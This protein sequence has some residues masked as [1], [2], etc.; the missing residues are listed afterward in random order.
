MKN[1]LDM[2]NPSHAFKNNPKKPSLI[3]LEFEGVSPMHGG[4]IVTMD[5]KP[6][7]LDPNNSVFR[8]HTEQ[9]M[10]VNGHITVDG[11]RYPLVEG[12][13]YRDKSWGPRHWH[14]FFWYRWVPMTFSRDFG[15]LLSINGRPDDVPH[16]SGNVLRNGIYEPVRK[17]ELKTDWDERNFHRSFV[18]NFETDKR[19]Y[20]MKAKVLTLIPLRHKPRPGQDP[21]SFTRIT[22]ALTVSGTSLL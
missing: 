3:E 11:T 8:G 21:N 19:A 2:A 17:I 15:V 14:N 20:E 6:I 4:E 12:T 22:E 7:E 1:P 9:N 5:G 18:A 10:A 16:V 13:G